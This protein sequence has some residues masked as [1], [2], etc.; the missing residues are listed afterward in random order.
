MEK[1]K[2]LNEE[3]TGGLSEYQQVLWKTA[4]TNSK[5]LLQGAG[6]LSLLLPSWSAQPAQVLTCLIM[7]LSVLMPSSLNPNN[8][9]CASADK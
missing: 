2:I 9:V 3:N 7:V 4:T 5:N 1:Y 8:L 6:A